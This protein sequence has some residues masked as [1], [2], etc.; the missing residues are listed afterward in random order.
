MSIKNKLTNNGF[1]FLEFLIIVAIIG[2]L[3]AISIP[4][5]GEYVT[6][7]KA[8][9]MLRDIEELQTAV[10]DYRVI[11]EKFT[12]V[13][14]AEKIKDTYDVANPAEKSD[15]I[16][17]VEVFSK[18]K[19][20]IQIV[21]LATGSSLSM[22]QGHSLELIF[23]GKWSKDE[24]TVWKCSAKG[25]VKYAPSKCREKKAKKETAKKEQANENND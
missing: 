4:A 11:N 2:V 13:A 25:Q 24:G 20:N 1:S 14:N 7:T 23:D 19:N 3:T 10:S 6:R 17:K 21:I 18:G 22:K 12:T 8:N 9:K 15:V 16:D 5:Y